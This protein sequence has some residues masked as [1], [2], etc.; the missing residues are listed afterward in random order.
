MGTAEISLDLVQHAFAK[1]GVHMKARVAFTCDVAP[2]SQKVLL[3]QFGGHVFGDVTGLT[4]P[5]GVH[6]SWSYLDKWAAIRDAPLN[7]AMF[8]QRWQ[9]MCEVPDTDLCTAGTPCQPWSASGDQFGLED[10]RI[11]VWLYFVKFHRARRTKILIHENVLG[12]P[13]ALAQVS[14]GDL[15]IIIC[16]V[17][18][19]ADTGFSCMARP[20]QYL[21]MLLRGAVEIHTD[22]PSMW[23]LVRQACANPSCTPD[24]AMIA[25]PEE[26]VDEEL[27]YCVRRHVAPRL[28]D[29][30]ELRDLSYLLLES[31]LGYCCWGMAK[32]ESPARAR[33]LRIAHSI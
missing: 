10:P 21:I 30:F 17:V 31:E 29:S 4:A 12:F 11:V 8:C 20:R 18:D 3:E 13:L 28:H 9:Q 2:A 27:Q 26:V 33:E 16:L 1:L 6:P 14:L 32:S 7:S 19:P 15:Y 24:A 25:P 22:I 23:Q 5:Y